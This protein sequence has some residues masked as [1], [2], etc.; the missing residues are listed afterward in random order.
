MNVYLSNNRRKGDRDIASAA[1][2][3]NTTERCLQPDDN[4]DDD[5]DGVILL[6]QRIAPLSAIGLRKRASAHCTPNEK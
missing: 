4:D 6:S 3:A 5:A 2:S 1:V